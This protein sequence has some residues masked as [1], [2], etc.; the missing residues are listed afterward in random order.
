MLATA[1]RIDGLASILNEIIITITTSN[2]T[3]QFVIQ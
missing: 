2:K 1:Y 3:Y